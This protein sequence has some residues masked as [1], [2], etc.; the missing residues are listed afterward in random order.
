M[1]GIYFP[2]NAKIQRSDN[3]SLLINS[4]KSFPSSKNIFK[5]PNFK[6]KNLSVTFP[7]PQNV[8]CCTCAKIPKT[9]QQILVNICEA[10]YEN[11]FQKFELNAGSSILSNRW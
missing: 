9:A 4:Y 3:F 10:N 1:R 11:E 2:S 6:S 8:P 5:S 7:K